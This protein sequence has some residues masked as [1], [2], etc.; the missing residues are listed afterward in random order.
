M[1][2][3]MAGKK[4]KKMDGRVEVVEE[5]VESVWEALGSMRE[6][7]SKI[8]TIEQGKAEI[9]T[10]LNEMSPNR[11]ELERSLTGVIGRPKSTAIGA[12]PGH[13]NAERN[14]EEGDS[15]RDFGGKVDNRNR[16]VEMPFFDG[17]NPDGWVSRAERFFK[18][19]RIGEREKLDAVMV[20]MEGEALTW[21]QYEDGRRPFGS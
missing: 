14:E 21:Y 7:I 10:R 9:L 19:N 20:N 2:Q 12:T 5:K 15:S 6:G 13:S 8:P 11:G 18:I 16:R 17:S 4:T 3:D 1:G